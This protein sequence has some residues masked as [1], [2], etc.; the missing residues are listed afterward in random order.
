MAHGLPGDVAPV[1][2][3]VSELRMHDGPDDRVCFPRRGEVWIVLLCGGDKK[4][5]AREIA[6]AKRLAQE[7]RESN[8]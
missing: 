1:G 6:T 3:D 4:T 5:Q 7:W 2:D 8:G